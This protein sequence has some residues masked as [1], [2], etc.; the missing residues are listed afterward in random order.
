MRLSVITQYRILSRQSLYTTLCRDRPLIFIAITISSM[1]AAQ[2]KGID[3]DNNT[4]T[5]IGAVRNNT[6]DTDLTA[7]VSRSPLRQNPVYQCAAAR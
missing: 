2:H 3:N 5:D 1:I 4:A 7:N 6:R